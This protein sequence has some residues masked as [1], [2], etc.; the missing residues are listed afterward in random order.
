MEKIL[1]K[2]K[3]FQYSLLEEAPVYFVAINT[4]GSTR[5][6]NKTMLKALGYQRE[7]VLNKDYLKQFVP[8]RQRNMVQ[9]IFS[10][11][12][13]NNSP[14]QNENIVLTKEGKEL[15]V[16]WYGKQ[17][18]NES[19]DFHYLIG[20]GIDVT[21]QKAKEKKIEMFHIKEREWNNLISMEQE[22]VLN[23][24]SEK[25]FTSKLR[26]VLE[27]ISKIIPHDGSDISLL[28]NNQLRVIAIHGYKEPSGQSIVQN[29]RQNL[30]KFPIDKEVIE[31]KKTII[32]SEV[33]KDSR[34]IIIPGLEW[35]RSGMK[36]P[37]IFEGKVLGTLGIVSEKPCAF[38]EKSIKKI[39]SFVSGLAIAIHNYQDYCQ[40]HKN[41]N[42]II[43]AITKLVEIRDPYTAGHQEGVANLATAI[44]REIG[45]AKEVIESIRIASLVHDIGKINVP[46][47]ILNKP[48][49]L[50]EVEYNLVKNH[51]QLGYDIL[52]E[53]SFDFPIAE[54]VHQHHEK[55][56]GSGYPQGLKGEQILL[57][58]RIICVADVFNAMASHR[59]YR[60]AL[61]IEVAKEELLKNRGVLY[62]PQVVDA[63]LKVLEKGQG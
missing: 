63:C 20:V 31:N 8:L 18:Y 3:E 1:T 45:L 7:E 62:D 56:N 46:S 17:I 10:R 55:I 13:K 60:A 47:E 23:L 36:I 54:I 5:F 15:L 22:M 14:T 44:A 9:N 35:I 51:P 41:K 32:I 6:M 42:D 39:E 48:S 33:L 57:E 24:I 27:F 21:E 50:N 38:N 52:K 28:E 25:D 37:F 12:Q 4:D 29:L 19:G 43:Y 16:R 61:G 11:L 30:D 2:E 34:W 53:I 58:A 49:H 59:P 26:R 40:L